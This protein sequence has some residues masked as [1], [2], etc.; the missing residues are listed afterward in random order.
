MAQVRIATTAIRRSGTIDD[1]EDPARFV[2]DA[3]GVIRECNAS[4]EKLFG[5]GP[6]ELIGRPISL[7][8]PSLRDRTLV[9][10][11]F[12][13][14]HLAFLCHCGALLESVRYDGKTFA[15]EV[16]PSRVGIASAPMLQLIVREA[17]PQAEMLLPREMVTH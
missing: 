10:G 6:R 5:Y 14:T 17:S 1:L 3:E 7:L 2:V 16:L 12:P 4:A 13:N 11:E 8:L 15:S 9:D